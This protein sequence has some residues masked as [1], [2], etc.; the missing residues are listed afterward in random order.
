[1]SYVFIGFV[2]VLLVMAFFL[3]A[4]VLIF[5][6]VSSFLVRSGFDDLIEEAVV[7][8]E[9]SAGELERRGGQAAAQEVLAGKLTATV[10]R[11]PGVSLALVSRS[12]SPA[13]DA[14]PLVVGPWRHLS[15]PEVL[16][17][18]MQPT[19]FGG[20]LAFALPGTDRTDLVARAVGL[21]V[22]PMADYAV[23]VDLP[24]AGQTLERLLETTGITLGRTAVVTAD[25]QIVELEVG[26]A[27][28][29]EAAV[30]TVPSARD[31]GYT[32]DW[33]TFF[34]Y[35]NWA[36]G[37]STKVSTA[38]QIRIS[39]IFTRISGARSGCSSRGS[40]RS[41]RHCSRR[42]RSRSGRAMCL[43]SIPTA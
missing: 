21:P 20:L 7:L 25:G 2:P 40:P 19:G 39:D 8:A 1:M 41:S 29:S 22:D 3:L 37:S 28:G 36:T 13:A 32:L 26:R 31:A 34:D 9:T 15:P 17:A 42:A 30:Q 18:W 10:G 5:L 24:V 12:G 4:G 27:F 23:V 38:I 35:T 6:N 33:V 11:H 43:R 14:V 16:P